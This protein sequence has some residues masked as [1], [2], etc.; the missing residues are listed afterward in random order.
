MNNQLFLTISIVVLS[1]GFF[2]LGLSSTVYRWRAFMN[3]P[4]WNGLTRPFLIIGSIFFVVG[5]ALVYLFYPK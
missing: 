4:A 5:L 1:I 3:K 2:F